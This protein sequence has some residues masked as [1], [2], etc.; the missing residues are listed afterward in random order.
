[1]QQVEDIG[2]QQI[3]FGMAHGGD[4]GRI[5]AAEIA[6]ERGNPEEVQGERE[7]RVQ[8]LAFPFGGD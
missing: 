2:G 6:V 3:R 7:E 1:M 4:E 8:R 5:E